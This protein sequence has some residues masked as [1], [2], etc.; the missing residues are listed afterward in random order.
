M[1]AAFYAE[2]KKIIYTDTKISSNAR[3]VQVV[4][5]QFLSLSL[6]TIFLF[7]CCL[8]HPHTEHST[9]MAAAA[10]SKKSDYLKNKIWMWNKTRKYF[11]IQWTIN[12]CAFCHIKSSSFSNLRLT[13][14]I[15]CW[16]FPGIR[17]WCYGKF[18]LGLELRWEWHEATLSSTQPKKE[19]AI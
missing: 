14:S 15:Y 19:K 18:S 12:A 4:K 6:F 2:V 7:L 8:F 11:T 17:S 16:W 10:V 3:S 5:L 9:V 1:R 13:I